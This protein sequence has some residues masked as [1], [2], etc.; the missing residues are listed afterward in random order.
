MTGVQTCALPISRAVFLRC[1][2]RFERI[3]DCYHASASVQLAAEALLAGGDLEGAARVARQCLDRIGADYRL[4]E[5]HLHVL[6]YETTI[7]ARDAGAQQHRDR[8]LELVAD[9]DVRVSRRIKR[10]LDRAVPH[11]KDRTSAREDP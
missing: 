3:G 8:C 4:L 7:R 11:G 1:A 5:A 6:L 2:T 9:M 10:R